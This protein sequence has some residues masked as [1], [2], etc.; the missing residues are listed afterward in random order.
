[1]Q[2]AE[3]FGP[4]FQRTL[5]LTCVRDHGLRSLVGRF[6]AERALGFT[7]PASAWAWTVIGHEEHPTRLMV[8]TASRRLAPSHPAKIGVGK[9][10]AADEDWRD[11]KFVAAEIVEW[12]RRQTF[13]LGF[14]EARKAWN[15]GDHDEAMAKMMGRIEEMQQYEVAT[16]DRSWFFE[17]FHS[18]Q[19]RRAIASHGLD[20]FPTGI[21]PLDLKLQGGLGYGELGVL[22]AYSG[23]GKTFGCVHMGYVTTRI[24]RKVLHFQIEGGRKMTEDRYESRFMHT[25]YTATR[26]GDFDTEAL[27]VMHREY[28]IYRE[29]LIIRGFADRDAWNV[30]TDDLIEELATLR[31]DHGWVPDMIV[32]DYGD[33]LESPGDSKPEKQEESFRRLHTIAERQDFPGH[34]GYAV[35]SPTQARR[36]EVGAEEKKHVLRDR[37]IGD[38][39]GKFKVSDVMLSLNQ[40]IAERDENKMRIALIKNRDSTPGGVIE[41]RTDYDHGALVDLTDTVVIED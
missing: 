13:M 8:E 20:K 39:Y 33:V 11:A 28:S 41:V 18:R 34:S 24:R 22:M 6:I 14:E 27:R 5:I 3:E 1:M 7:D 25:L 40:T 4:D 19:G 16:A 12:A 38:S 29:N 23:I 17:E 21:D 35:W 26:R 37:D 2:G 10:I 30:T 15:A 9:L 32:V 36:P 31:R